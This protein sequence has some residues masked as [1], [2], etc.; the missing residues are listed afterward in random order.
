MTDKKEY[1]QRLD[2]ILKKQDEL[3]NHYDVKFEQQNL[4]NETLLRQ[5]DLLENDL[6]R[7]KELI[8][9]LKKSLTQHENVIDSLKKELEEQLKIQQK[10]H[11]DYGEIIEKLSD[12]VEDSGEIN[13]PNEIS[14]SENNSSKEDSLNEDN[15]KVILPPK[16]FESDYISNTK[17]MISNIKEKSSEVL[18]DISESDNFN[19]AP[20]KNVCPNCGANVTESSY[21]CVSCGNKLN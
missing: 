19:Q 9:D 6:K 4:L 16:D 7:H 1:D 21:F 20:T 14:L 13:A 2:S 15:G 12:E 5:N 18:K 3:L 10:L 8:K 11:R 17:S